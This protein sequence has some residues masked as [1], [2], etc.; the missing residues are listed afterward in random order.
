VWNVFVIEDG[1][2][3]RRQLTIGRRNGLE[4]QVL[5]GLQAGEHVILYPSELID[6][7]AQVE[8]H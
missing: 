7:G 6:E 4:A 8:R 5:E 1:L 2:A 3:T